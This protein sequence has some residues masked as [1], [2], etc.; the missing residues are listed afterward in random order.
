MSQ[1]Y[2]GRM[3]GG[4]HAG[5]AIAVKIVDSSLRM[6]VDCDLGLMRATAAVLELVPRLHWLSLRETVNEFGHLME[7]QVLFI[8]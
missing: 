8:V 7:T 5:R 6:A 1:V 2:K 3:I 4:L